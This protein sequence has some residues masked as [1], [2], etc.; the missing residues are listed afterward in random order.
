V[1][2]LLVWPVTT[3][4]VFGGFYGPSEP[5]AP[6]TAIYIMLPASDAMDTGKALPLTFPQGS[7][8]LLPNFAGT[9]VAWETDYEPAFSPNGKQVAYVRADSIT[10]TTLGSGYVS[11]PSLRIVN[12][13]ATDDHEVTNFNTGLYVTHLSWSPDGTQLVFDLGPQAIGPLN[14]PYLSAV[15][16]TDALF[17]INTNGTGLRRLQAAPATWP[18]WSA[19]AA[20]GVP[21]RLA[22]A[23]VPGGKQLIFSWPASAGN[24]ALE[25]SAQLGAAASWQGVTNAP[26]ASNGLQTLTLDVGSGARFFRLRNPF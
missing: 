18:V 21:P 10:A 22:L 23:V 26:V 11:Q 20:G 24:W 8:G 25:A 3:N 14:F 4:V 5:P 9:Y 2:D 16:Q 1:T 19:V 15:P 12:I 13:D 7:A 6:V 17:L